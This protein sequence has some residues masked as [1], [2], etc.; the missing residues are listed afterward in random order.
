MRRIS[1]NFTAEE[2][3]CHCG[4][5]DKATADVELVWLLELIR[6]TFGGRPVDVHSWFRCMAHNNRPRHEYSA[7]GIRGVGSN[8]NSWHPTGGA[9]DISIRGVKP[10][11]IQRF[12]RERF[13]NRYGV[14]LYDTFVHI[15]VRQGRGDWD[16]RTGV[17]YV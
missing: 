8:D 17:T 15:D 10:I 14:G 1:D 16:E 6:R 9:A 7:A 4:D 12:M 3:A 2:N 11:E 5:C 13:P